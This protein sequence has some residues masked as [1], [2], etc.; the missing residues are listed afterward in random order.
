[1][2]AQYAAP[3]FRRGQLP[4]APLLRGGLIE[5][6]GPD[7]E[8]EEEVGL[9]DFDGGYY[10]GMPASGPTI[11]FPSAVKTVDRTLLWRP[12][13]STWVLDR[14]GTVWSILGL[15]LLTLS[16]WVTVGTWPAVPNTIAFTSHVISSPYFCGVV[17]ALFIAAVVVTKGA[18]LKALPAIIRGIPVVAIV[19]YKMTTNLVKLGVI[20]GFALVRLSRWLRRPRTVSP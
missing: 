15:V 10:A 9:G 16:I 6:L 7:D 13:P 5:D 11:V 4:Q 20:T 2:A 12:R 18:A 14:E 19:A 17:L 8:D 1:V 3:T